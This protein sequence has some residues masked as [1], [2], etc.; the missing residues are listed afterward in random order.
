MVRPGTANASTF[1]SSDKWSGLGASEPVV[2]ALQALGITRPSH[3]Q[4]RS[5]QPL[6]SGLL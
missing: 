6:A 4:V 3:I 1:F 5:R 2:A